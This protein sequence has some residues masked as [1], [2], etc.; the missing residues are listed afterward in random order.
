MHLLY[1]SDINLLIVIPAQAGIQKMVKS[2]FLGNHQNSNKIKSHLFGILN[3][4]MAAKRHKNHKNKILH[5]II[6][7]GYETEIREFRLFTRLSI[8]V[9][10]ICLLFVFCYLKFFIAET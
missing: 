2:D 9:I 10:V 8:L 4:D 7:I 6:T 5:L 1:L 3:F